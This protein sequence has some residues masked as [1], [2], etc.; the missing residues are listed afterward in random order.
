[1][2]TKSRC[3]YVYI[4]LTIIPWAGVVYEL[5]ANELRSAELAM[6]SYTMRAIVIIVLLYGQMRYFWCCV[7]KQLLDF[8]LIHFSISCSFTCS[9]TLDIA[10]HIITI[11]LI[12]NI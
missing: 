6:S 4:Y 7:V 11:G 9:F 8:L 1:M 12:Q 10:M 3:K 2:Q 5:M